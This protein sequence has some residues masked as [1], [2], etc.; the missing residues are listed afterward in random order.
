MR[1][2][3]LDIIR[4]LIASEAGIALPAAVIVLSIMTTLTAAAVTVSVSTSSSTK[5]DDNRKAALEAAEAGL[6]VGTYRLTLINP[7]INPEKPTE[8]P[9]CVGQ[10]SKEETTTSTG[11][12]ESKEEELGNGAKFK[13]W[14]TP[15]LSETGKCVGGV[16]T[17]TI[18]TSPLAQR[19]V[20]AQGTVGNVT[21][22]VASRVATFIATPLFPVHGM[23]GLEGVTL[24]GK[25]NV[26]SALGSNKEITGVG[27]DT[28]SGEI[29]LGPSGSYSLPAGFT[30]TGK[31]VEPSP[32]VLSPVAPQNSATTNDNERIT[33]GLDAHTGKVEYEPKNR[34]LSLT[35]NA[36]LKIGGGTGIYNFCSFSAAANSELTVTAPAKVEI[37]IDSPE[38]PGSGC[39]A[40]TG[41]FSF[42]GSLSN[43]SNDPTA[44][45]I[46]VY[47]AGTDTYAGKVSAAATIFAPKATLVMQGN[48]TLTGGVAAKNIEVGGT[49][50]FTWDKREETLQA[51]PVTQYYRT[52]WEECS[53]STE[54]GPQ[55]GC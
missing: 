50:N 30:V 2:T 27:V 9:S 14:T 55:A 24:K 21:R 44:L 1:R 20:I 45:K 29:V 39:P 16:V 35:G 15:V 19:C 34:E 41:T 25:D 37:I 36:T 4:R 33:S 23:T 13:F 47:G 52:A 51:T 53:A 18:G 10:S 38:D 42:S 31:T 6:K 7:T 48:S 8:N 28:G 11:Y 46:F 12:C 17:N 22:R 3:S 40:G 5:R 26:I 49:V 32:L 43:P 54:S